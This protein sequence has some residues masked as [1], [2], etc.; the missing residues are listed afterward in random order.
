MVLLVHKPL[1]QTQVV[2][3]IVSG[4]IYVS[5]QQEMLRGEPQG[6]L[7]GPLLFIFFLLMIY[8][9]VFRITMLKC[10]R[11]IRLLPY[12]KLTSETSKKQ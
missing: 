2:T 7:L 12:Q 5:P 10:L 3:I 11:M 9:L 8:I 1:Q 4:I 6:S